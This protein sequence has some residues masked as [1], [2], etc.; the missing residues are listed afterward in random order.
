MKRAKMVRTGVIALAMVCAGAFA[1]A[2]SAKLKNAVQN[3]FVTIPAG[4]LD[5]Y[6]I[7]KTEVPQWMYKEVMGTNP[8]KF[9]DNNNPVENMRIDEAIVF[10]NK[11]SMMMNL[12]PVYT[13]KG[14]TN[15]A[16]WGAVPTRE[17]ADWKAVKVDYSANGFRLPTNLEWTYAA[18]EGARP[19]TYKYSGSNDA[20][21]VAW[22]VGNSK[23][24]R[25]YVPHNVGKKTP[26][27][28]GLYDMSGNVA[29]FALLPD[30]SH[31]L[32][33]PYTYL[34]GAYNEY[35]D[36]VG[37][38]RLESGGFVSYVGRGGSGAGTGI[39]L[40]R[41]V[42]DSGDDEDF[43]EDDGSAYDFV[44][45]LGDSMKLSG[46]WTSS[47]PAVIVISKK[48]KATAV[49]EGTATLTSSAGKVVKI[50]VED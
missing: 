41:T 2:Q 43:D 21:R 27:A 7:M 39:R 33:E 36:G 3:D 45:E 49:G 19:S 8:S 9:K 15:P 24:G 32:G 44:F 50:K 46:T 47:N 6:M 18:K 48:G 17:D 22:Y 31:S 25:D 26:N 37:G 38:G 13:I 11:L 30:Y 14:S 12:T 40:V 29:E 35:E 34:G 28:L 1:S 23:V 20:D 16:R 10:C 5:S 42:T 4:K